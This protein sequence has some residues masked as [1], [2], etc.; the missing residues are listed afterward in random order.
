MLSVSRSC[1]RRSRWT[2]AS[3]LVTALLGWGLPAQAADWEETFEG[4]LDLDGW[5]FL[6]VDGVSPNQVFAPPQGATAI[7]SL[8]GEPVIEV[9]GGNLVLDAASRPP[10]AGGPLGSPQIILGSRADTF[11]DVKLTSNI[12]L[13]A[14]GNQDIALLARSDV[15]TLSGYAFG[16]DGFGK[17]F[18]ITKVV[19]GGQ[20]SDS[21][22]PKTSTKLVVPQGDYPDVFTD[23]QVT[24]SSTPYLKGRVYTSQAQD[25]FLGQ[26][27]WIDRGFVD[28][29][30]S[31]T[32]FTEGTSGL[33]VQFQ[34]TTLAPP[35]D[36]LSMEFSSIGSRAVPTSAGNDFFDYRDD[37]ST[38]TTT[39]PNAKFDRIEPLN[40]ALPLDAVTGIAGW[41]PNVVGPFPANVTVQNGQL[42]ADSPVMQ[43]EISNNPNLGG[44]V[45]LD[46]AIGQGRTSL[47]YNEREFSHF[48]TMVDVLDFN[49]N[50]DAIYGLSARGTNPG[51][52]TS[53]SIILTLNAQFN[54]L[55]MQHIEGEVPLPFNQNPGQASLGEAN[56]PGD[57]PAQQQIDPNKNYR[58]VFTG[59]GSQ[60]TAVVYDLADL[61][62]PLGA[63]GTNYSDTIWTDTDSSW[64]RGEVAPVNVDIPS[65]NGFTAEHTTGQVGLVVIEETG[66]GYGTGRPEATF[67]NFVASDLGF[68]GSNGVGLQQYQLPGNGHWFDVWAWAGN[69]VPDGQTF[70][71]GGPDE[72]QIGEVARFGRFLEKDATITIS[73]STPGTQE[74]QVGQLVFDNADYS[75][76]IEGSTPADKLIIEVQRPQ[77]DATVNFTE[78]RTRAAIDVL[79]GHH[80]INADLEARGGGDPTKP[81]GQFDLEVAADSSLTINGN[82]HFADGSNYF[83]IGDLTKWGEGTLTLNGDVTGQDHFIAVEQGTL[84]LGDGVTLGA[85][86]NAARLEL[87]EVIGTANVQ[88]D[89]SVETQ[90][91]GGEMGVLAMDLGGDVLGQDLLSITSGSIDLTNMLLELAFVGEANPADLI[92]AGTYTLI[93]ADGGVTDTFTSVTDL[94]IYDDLVGIQYTPNSVTITLDQDLVL[95]DATLDGLVNLDDLDLLAMNLGTEGN[96]ILADFNGDFLVNE[97][98]LDLIEMNWGAGTGGNVPSFE[99]ALVIVGLADPSPTVIPEPTAVVLLAGLLGAVGLRRHR[100]TK[101]G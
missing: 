9:K 16:H 31:P 32:A 24:G 96:W 8:P 64:D 51:L 13:S 84:V 3:L 80:V 97:D 23:F 58:I 53:D 30:A 40:Q 42:T 19:N 66:P 48:R 88:G 62:N 93:T 56:L 78:A 35:G 94:G 87:G 71:A 43:D 100:L 15:A 11:G 85:L 44:N 18:S 14:T 22:T 60:L 67:D 99:E 4:G 6:S 37:F 57:L 10:A 12:P 46:Q 59:L 55:Q 17:D 82:I 92:K 33:A 69:D 81:G 86:R 26:L 70:V 49:P 52:G 1:L 47:S 38:D 50:R 29:N 2:A 61:D 63:F 75:I 21:G 76:T 74:A 73:D 90:E 28:G 95:G 72:T 101:L 7:N 39:G 68:T 65:L 20:G 45:T 41:N 54:A 36:P 91:G 98:D 34:D 79:A 5:T 77:T 89:V 25:Q 83:R 27:T